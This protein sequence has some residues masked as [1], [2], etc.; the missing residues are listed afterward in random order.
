MSKLYMNA[1]FPQVAFPNL[2]TL[3]LESLNYQN[4]WDIATSDSS[5]SQISE[6]VESS[7]LGIASNDPLLDGSFSNL[8]TLKVFKCDFV[9]KLIPLYI[10]KS[11]SNLEELEIRSCV[12]LEVV[13]DFGEYNDHQETNTFLLKTLSL[14]DLPKLKT[15]WG[16]GFQGIV[17]FQSLQYVGVWNCEI[18]E[19]IFP[20]SIAKGLIQLEELEMSNCG[21]E[22]IVAKDEFLPEVDATFVFPKLRKLEI[23]SCEKLKTSQSELSE[24]KYSL[25]L[26]GK[27]PLIWITF[28]ELCLDY[29]TL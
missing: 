2:E 20:A 9:L 11:L 25:S 7:H 26:D 12:S 21:V 6:I 23:K 8:K 3:C 27:V 15:V 4:I 10:L 5:G 24:T 14:V 13:F 18:L 29:I 1:S 19:N 17:N 16:R 22:V 28:L